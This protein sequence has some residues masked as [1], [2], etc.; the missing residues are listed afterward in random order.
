MRLNLIR[1][2]YRSF[3]D[4]QKRFR[5]SFTLLR[6]SF[7]WLKSSIFRIIKL[8]DLIFENDHRNI[9][10]YFIKFEYRSLS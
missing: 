1:E 8:I 2:I 3:G 5:R 7:N 10:I 9:D 4:G 6:N